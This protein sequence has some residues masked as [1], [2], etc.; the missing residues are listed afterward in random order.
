MRVDDAEGRRF[1]L[2]IEENPHQHDVLDDIGEAAGMEGVTV[3][4]RRGLRHRA[5]KVTLHRSQN[6]LCWDTSFLG[7]ASASNQESRDSGF[8]L[9]ARPGMTVLEISRPAPAAC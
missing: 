7:D 3:V 4:H 6:G 2:Q 8:A 5:V 1:L 9:I